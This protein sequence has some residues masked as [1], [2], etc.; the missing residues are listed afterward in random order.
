MI[1]SILRWVIVG[2]WLLGHAIVILFFVGVAVGGRKVV[3][4]ICNRH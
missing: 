3:Q 4:D 1:D 2:G